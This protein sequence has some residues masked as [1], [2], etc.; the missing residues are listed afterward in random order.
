MPGFGQSIR[1]H[2][3]PAG[4]F[5]QVFLLLG[6]RAEEDHGQT[7]DAGLNRQGDTESGDTLADVLG[8][9]GS[10]H[11]IQFRAFVHLRHIRAEKTQFPRLLQ[12]LP[13][14]F[15]I[16]LR[17]FL[18]PGQKFTHA[19]LHGTLADHDLFFVKVLGSEHLSGR[20]I[21]EKKLPPFVKLQ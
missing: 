16:A 13:Q 9:Q 2:P 1:T 17:Q 12:E 6:R 11:L 19:E 5:G 7:S 8:D 10:A 3:L 21:H 4:Q 18:P 15:W 20:R 14:K